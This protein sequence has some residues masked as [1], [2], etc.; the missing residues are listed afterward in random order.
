MSR[1]CSKKV[2]ALYGCL[3]ISDVD[4]SF[5]DVSWTVNN[6]FYQR[7]F[8]FENMNLT[9]IN[10]HN[11]IKFQKEVKAKLWRCNASVEGVD[12]K[13]SFFPRCTNIS[14]QNVCFSQCNHNNFQLVEF[15]HVCWFNDSL[16]WS[17]AISKRPMDH[18]WYL[19]HLNSSS[20]HRFRG[21]VNS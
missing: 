8:F 10:P 4:R 16:R 14:H 20:S 17:A 1:P 13:I 12:T 15:I 21:K 19:G 9:S 3:K 7:F 2:T 5:R 11:D 18:G 6:E